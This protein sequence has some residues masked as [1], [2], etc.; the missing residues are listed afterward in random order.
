DV[1]VDQGPGNDKKIMRPIVV[2]AS[3]K[4]G[5]FMRGGLAIDHVGNLKPR[6]GNLTFNDW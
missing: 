1:D 5:L 3:V 2:Q 4:N 6:P